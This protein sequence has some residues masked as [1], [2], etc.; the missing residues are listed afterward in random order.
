MRFPDYY[1]I[2]GV[3]RNA[4]AADIQKAFRARAREFHPDR[5]PGDPTAET[6][7]IEAKEAYEVL[8]DSQARTHYDRLSRA[9]TDWR[10]EGMRAAFD[11]SRWMMQGGEGPPP[12]SVQQFSEFFSMVFSQ[13]VPLPPNQ[14]VIQITLGEAYEGT[15]KE[16]RIYDQW[17]SLQIPRGVTH[18][19]Q[20]KYPGILSRRRG[21]AGDVVLTVLLEEHPL[22]RRQ[23]D[24]LYAE[25]TIDLYTAVLG[26]QLQLRTLRGPFLL[27]VPR[28]V[29]PHQVFRIERYGMPN[30]KKTGQLGDLYVTMLVQIPSTLSDDQGALFSRLRELHG[31]NHVV[32]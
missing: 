29:Q 7:F 18:Y 27:Q 23:G 10:G 24:D 6:R 20:I 15:T 31:G 14:P 13:P 12:A 30:L 1:A 26:G 28:G 17:I 8:N 9:Y 4:S 19:S 2:L 22:F 5:N 21:P 32:G 3:S 11:W 25:A 16:I